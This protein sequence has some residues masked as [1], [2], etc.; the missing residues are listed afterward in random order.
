MTDNREHFISIT[1]TVAG[2]LRQYA[3][4]VDEAFRMSPENRVLTLFDLRDIFTK[5][6][7]EI[8]TAIG[9]GDAEPHAL[10]QTAYSLFQDAADRIDAHL[11][12]RKRGQA[13]HP[14][15]KNDVLYLAVEL[16]N[17]ADQCEAAQ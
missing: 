12:D 4:L 8:H 10:N 14:P 1:P 2:A 16:R 7:I 5:H 17:L 11:H 13:T 6:A 9:A 15:T 3:F